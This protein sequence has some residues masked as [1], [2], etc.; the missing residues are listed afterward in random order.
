M[1][2]CQRALSQFWAC[3]R[4]D[5]EMASLHVSRDYE[6]FDPWAY[7]DYQ[8]GEVNGFHHH[9]LKHIHEF[10]KSCWSPSADL[11]VLDFNWRWSSYRVCDK[12][13]IVHIWNSAFSANRCFCVPAC[14]SS[15]NYFAYAC[16]T[17]VSLLSMPNGDRVELWRFAR[18]PTVQIFDRSQYHIVR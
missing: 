13:V 9:S 2:V 14:L 12:G 15:S 8:Y 1:Y 3:S 10:Y 5:N 18:L 4:Q 6:M 11:K 7:L 17:P 16:R